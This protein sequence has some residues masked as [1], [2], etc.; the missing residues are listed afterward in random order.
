MGWVAV[1]LSLL[2]PLYRYGRSQWQRPPQTTHGQALFAGIHYRRQIVR[3]P[4]PFVVHI[5]QIDLTHPGIK[6]ISTPGQPAPDNNEF[7]AETTSS[8][9]QRFQLQLAINAGY[10]Y[11]F[12]ERTPWDYRPRVGDRVNVLG[13]S[14][15]QGQHYSPAQSQWPVLC[16][17]AN[18]RGQIIETGRCPI[19]TRNAVAGNYLLHPHRPLNLDLDKP[20]ART[21]AA[22]NKTGDTLWLILVDGKQPDYSEGATMADIEQIVWRLGAA[23][24]LNLD[25]GG[26][27]TMVTATA[28]GAKVLNAPIHGKWPMQER[29]VATHLGVYAQPLADVV[30]AQNSHNTAHQSPD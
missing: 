15:A 30:A 29:P 21:V 11:H 23:V 14:I 4:R 9:L 28:S 22:L 17:D 27:A 26:S 5:A 2:M 13:Q 8:F 19:G 12:Y 20:Y 3:D 7:D 18:Q 6:V 24:A 25:G 10:F 16:F 1:S